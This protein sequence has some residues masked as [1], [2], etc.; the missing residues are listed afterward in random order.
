MWKVV[1]GEKRVNGPPQQRF[2][3]WRR[4]RGKSWWSTRTSIVIQARGE[5]YLTWNPQAKKT[6]VH[7]HLESYWGSLATSIHTH[8]SRRSRWLNPDDKSPDSTKQS[9][10]FWRNPGKEQS[11]KGTVHGTEGKVTIAGSSQLPHAVSRPFANNVDIKRSARG[12]C[13]APQSGT[14]IP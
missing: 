4:E 9:S 2:S 13:M 10:Y 14:Y 11:E 8:V 6:L 12:T 1:R 3:T 5:D 7:N